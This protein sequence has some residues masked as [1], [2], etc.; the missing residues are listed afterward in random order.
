MGESAGAV[1][2]QYFFKHIRAICLQEGVDNGAVPI[3]AVRVGLGGV[4]NGL[5]RVGGGAWVDNMLGWFRGRVG[6]RS[7]LGL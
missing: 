7:G 1:D 4:G 6:A 5:G 2:K 3:K